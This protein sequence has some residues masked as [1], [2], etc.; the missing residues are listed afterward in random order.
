MVHFSKK[1]KA[2]RVSSTMIVDDRRSIPTVCHHCN[3]LMYEDEIQK[4]SIH[5]FEVAVFG[6]RNEHKRIIY[7]K[8]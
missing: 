6:R 5:G 4:D 1:G 3:E 7:I 2:Y 8:R